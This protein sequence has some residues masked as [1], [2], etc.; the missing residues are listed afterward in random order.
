MKKWLRV[1]LAMAVGLYGLWFA[2]PVRPAAASGADTNYW[3]TN[4]LLPPNLF[5]KKAIETPKGI[6]Y[7][8]SDYRIYYTTSYWSG[9][10]DTSYYGSDLE[11][12]A[13]GNLYYE[14]MGNIYKLTTDENQP[15]W[16]LNATLRH[17]EQGIT[18]FGV[19]SGG[20]LYLNKGSSVD[21]YSPDDQ[22][23]GSIKHF[24]GPTDTLSV[25]FVKP[26]ENGALYLYDDISHSVIK[27]TSTDFSHYSA[28]NAQN[29]PAGDTVS[30]LVVQNGY[31]YASFGSSIC[32]YKD[33][34]LYLLQTIPVSGG[35][36]SLAG[37]SWSNLY[38]VA[39]NDG[40]AY[41]MQDTAY[42]AKFAGPSTVV[43]NMEVTLTTQLTMRTAGTPFP[44]Q[45][46]SYNPTNPY[47]RFY[48]KSSSNS[49]I[50]SENLN[51]VDSDGKATVVANLPADVYEISVYGNPLVDQATLKVQYATSTELEITDVDGNPSTRPVKG[52]TVHLQAR[53]SAEGSSVSSGTVSFYDGSTLIGS[54]ISVSSSGSASFDWQPTT[55]GAHSIRAEYNGT[56]AY[57]R[58]SSANA[59]ITV[60]AAPA[61]STTV[62]LD[63][64]DASVL[65]GHDP[66]WTA[67]VT[68]GG[69]SA[70]TGDVEFYADGSKVGTVPLNGGVASFKP[71]GLTAGTRYVKA[72]YVG[73][74][75]F[76]P[77]DSPD[78]RQRVNPVVKDL[79]EW[80]NKVL[81]SSSTGIEQAAPLPNGGLVYLGMD[82]S[83]YMWQICYMGND[84][85]D[86]NLTSASGDVSYSLLK[87]GADGN[88]YIIA[89][90]DI[91][92]LIVN[93][94]D[95]T[96]S[97][98]TSVSAVGSLT[99]YAVDGRGN[100]YIAR[101]NAID[102][103]GADGTP[104]GSYHTPDNGLS[105]LAPSKLYVS[106]DGMLYATD[107]GSRKILRYALSYGESGHPSL[108]FEAATDSLP[109]AVNGLVAQN[110]KLFVSG[111]S[112]GT[113]IVEEFDAQA[114]VVTDQVSLAGNPPIGTIEGS[115][116]GLLYVYGNGRAALAQ[117]QS[118][119]LT[120]NAP[121]EY[122]PGV[123]VKL[124]AQ[125]HMA[126]S[127]TPYP[128][129][130]NSLTPFPFSVVFYGYDSA[131]NEKN[132]GN[133]Q[134]DPSSGAAALN[135]ALEPGTVAIEA[136]R[137][138]G[139]E[140]SGRVSI[141]PSSQSMTSTQLEV[142]SVD[143]SYPGAVTLHA[144]VTSGVAV[145]S[146]Q[147]AFYDGDDLLGTADVNENGVA[148][149]KVGALIVGDHSFTASYLAN[150]DFLESGSDIVPVAIGR[151]TATVKAASSN[152][153]IK[154]GETAVWTAQVTNKS[155]GAVQTGSV[156][157]LIGYTLVC[158]ALP[159]DAT[160]KA[161]CDLAQASAGSPMTL[162]AGSY[163][164][165]V[166]YN[167]DSQY[168]SAKGQ[169]VQEVVKR[170]TT[171]TVAVSAN[172]PQ[173]GDTVNWTAT[174]TSGGS[175]ALN[176]TVD[177]RNSEGDSLGQAELSNDG[178]AVL[179]LSDMAR[180]AYVVRAYY[181][182]DEAHAES[183]SD[184]VET[185]VNRRP[186]QVLLEQSAGTTLAGQ[187]ARF[188]VT[189][190][191]ESGTRKP[192]GIV[193]L[194]EEAGGTT[195]ILGQA[196]LTNGIA[197]FELDDLPAGDH[198]ISAVYT[199]DSVFD[200]QTTESFIVHRIATVTKVA[201]VTEAIN[202]TAGQRYPL[203]VTAT[204]SDGSLHQVTSEALI[205]SSDS[206]IASV[207]GGIVT[208]NKPGF[209]SVAVSYGGQTATVEVT[210]SA[211]NAAPEALG[212]LTRTTTVGGI[213][214][215]AA[216]DLATD[217]DQDV[218][219]LSDARSMNSAVATASIESGA[220]KIVGA[221]A[222]SATVTAIADDGHGHK[223]NV[224]VAVTVNAAVAPAP[225]PADPAPSNPPSI[226]SRPSDHVERTIKT[227]EG[228][229]VSL[230]DVASVSIPA[231]ALHADGTIEASVAASDQVPSAGDRIRLSSVI[232][233]TS[234]SGTRFLRPLQLT[235]RFSV[236]DLPSGAEP[237]VY[238]FNE[239]QRRWIYIGG[240]R[241][242]TDT[243]EVS[244]NHFTKFGVFASVQPNFTDL[245]G[246]WGQA[247][248][249]RLIG[250]GVIN[251][252][253][254]GTFRP[255]LQVTR[256]QFVKMLAV[257]MAL[258]PA[259]S[260]TVLF[261]DGPTIPDWAK[262]AVASAVEAGLIRGYEANGKVFFHPDQTITRVEMAVILSRV[263]GRESI[264][265]ASD[266]AAFADQQSIPSWASD[267]VAT[268]VD[269]A[270]VGGY[271]DGSFRPGSPATRAETV[272]MI[273]MLLQA[274]HL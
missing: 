89:D 5:V 165:T 110:G 90:G 158:G 81:N 149:L 225:V 54:E 265:P 106:E 194:G 139:S 62:T 140:T 146:G 252:F 176:G 99:D 29:V 238:Y 145:T 131:G 43:P 100:F 215:L 16:I 204:Y 70:V 15:P 188:T 195:N 93:G 239:T 268:V 97:R 197:S 124:A 247:F 227:S 13:D 163:P 126:A 180:G 34:N 189:V 75:K 253:G 258:K 72:H 82:R 59:T 137:Y 94:T 190:V 49:L 19:D 172:N 112:N 91:V 84:T 36:A 105:S 166:V 64:S 226:P 98:Q 80:A 156:T 47:V 154:V 254:D 228:G 88:N 30:G 37:G 66:T 61:V 3:V 169:L 117:N 135:V 74:D 31:V 242:G 7:L 222:G 103:Y 123:P 203:E 262:N 187:T 128:G 28:T 58:S 38:I 125:M 273:Y 4:D 45:I 26:G 48:V 132:L 170:A 243:L 267:A 79:S 234:S 196:I 9:F 76:L 85:C 249:D 121:T 233:F 272:K 119:T 8:G 181:S 162:K 221:G 167:G 266:R 6:Y 152:E 150:G 175:G 39:S 214:M 78:I 114:L 60:D 177:F 246:H 161:V 211:A 18:S 86:A 257:A 232:E 155:G 213:T 183:G 35:I 164:V 115:F 251:G 113:G 210:V 1:A 55:T 148:E 53:V 127:G 77:S 147:V 24:L 212:G 207:E 271:T 274:L 118:F 41:R 32:Q 141:A 129:S 206:A 130:S 42:S 108:A 255:D 109:F 153:S 200:Q 40:K 216:G 263:L 261:S 193:M 144:V 23:L 52:E 21:I 186:V 107:S 168:T 68:A 244:V 71:S 224:S 67:G 50:V 230:G 46:H 157:F 209:A 122:I 240:V 184:P 14:S 208:A 51:Y 17:N 104:L 191:P 260:G 237:A 199:G 138:G 96:F 33:S 22:L 44:G 219:T 217:P 236:N 229:S 101:S 2:D 160:G 57:S 63:T 264:P 151:G 248:A 12:G 116:G 231:G 259:G 133:A 20:R 142:Q 56:S 11:Y 159:L 218:L 198:S 173:V 102:L 87:H 185:V 250:M 95:R 136:K 27:Y 171:T 120:A 83:L 269:Q 220:L 10:Q 241:K 25:Q 223:V 201:L 235:L 65:F 178:K 245:A 205:T 192:N 111:N 179:T 92:K 174:V 270:I 73:S 182:G 256:A 143:A 134:F 202:V 69:G